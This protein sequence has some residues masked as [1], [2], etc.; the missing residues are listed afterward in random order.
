VTTSALWLR[1]DLRLADAPALLAARDAATDVLPVFV[2]DDRLRRPS[3]APRLAFLYRCLRELELRTDGALRV[4]TGRPED[5]LPRLVARSGAA[6][7]HISSDHAPYGRE[8]DARV[9]SA[10]QRLDAPVPLVAT[11]SPYAVTP[12]ALRKADGEPFRVYSPYAGA[13]RERGVRSPAATPGAV[14]WTDGGIATDGVPPDPDLGP[15]RLPAAG[16]QAALER[17]HR[18]R[19]GGLSAYARTRDSPGSDGTSVMSA[20]LKYGC[21][22]P[23]TML[24]DLGDDDGAR[25]LRGELA[26]RDFY[27]DVLWH[28]PE[29]ARTELSP[30]MAGLE[31]DEGAQADRRFEAWAS[32]RTG[33]PFVDAGMRQLLGEAWVHNRV[34]MVVASFLVK[35]LH[36]HWRRGA[37]HFMR[38]LRDGDLAS[39]QHGWQWVAGTGTDP[40][41]Y[42]RIFNPVSQGRQHDPDGTYVRRWV[43][44]LREVEGDAVHAPWTLP[45]GPPAG[46]PA[47]VVDHKAEREEALRRYAAVR[48]R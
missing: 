33:F 19:D 11:G 44:E 36:L 43:P 48:G 40:A 26:W 5:V 6:S 24:A 9:A 12:G 1:R 30:A 8:R 23:R 32:G 27:A 35:D 18:Y 22:H 4:L 47:P 28:R 2:L 39:N 15:A 7:V 45:D 37:R 34:R 20:Y 42:F 14:R 10:L 13:W 46:Y 31:Y 25:K 29:S 17:W 41:P 21:I 38:H 16:E 3:G